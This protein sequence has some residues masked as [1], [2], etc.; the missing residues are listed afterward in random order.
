MSDKQPSRDRDP[1]PES[2][3][4]SIQGD[5]MESFAQAVF[6]SPAQKNWRYQQKR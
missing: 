4:E 6:A 1:R 3:F 2:E 5:T